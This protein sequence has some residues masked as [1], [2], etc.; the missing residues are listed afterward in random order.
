MG[1]AARPRNPADRSGVKVYRPKKLA[2]VKYS[3]AG[4][5]VKNLD[6]GDALVVRSGHAGG[7][8]QFS[9]SNANAGLIAYGGYYSWGGGNSDIRGFDV[10]ALKAEHATG[11][12][13]RARSEFDLTQMAELFRA[14]NDAA[15]PDNTY[16]AIVVD[17]RPENANEI[18]P[19]SGAKRWNE[20]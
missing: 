20:Q 9:Y 10:V 12:P 8:G 5:Y 2:N 17:S 4:S 13:F 7:V 14:Y 15:M 3:S 19:T 1:G 18:D 16:S 11:A 6:N